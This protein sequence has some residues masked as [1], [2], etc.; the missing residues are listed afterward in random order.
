[1]LGFLLSFRTGQAYKRFWTGAC[2]AHETTNC[3]FMAASNLVAFVQCGSGDEK[4]KDVFR[5][6]IVRLM[7]MLNSMMLQELEGS[8]ITLF[9]QIPVMDADSLGKK[10]LRALVGE[11]NK[12]QLVLQWIKTLVIESVGNDVLSVP[13]PILTR[14]FQELD[15][16]MTKFHSAENISLVPFPFPYAATMEL[17]L[18]MHTL[19]TPLVMMNLL[20]ASSVLPSGF[21]ALISF[22]LW[23]IHL[24]AGELEDPFTAGANDLDLETLQI[25]LNEK[26]KTICCVNSHQVP[27]LTVDAE[28]ASH[29]LLAYTRAPPKRPHRR[30]VIQR[31]IDTSV[32][33]T[34]SFTSTDAVS[35]QRGVSRPPTFKGGASVPSE[36][37]LTTCSNERAVRFASEETEEHDCG[38]VRR[39][40]GRLRSLILTRISR[41][42]PTVESPSFS[43]TEVDSSDASATPEGHGEIAPWGLSADVTAAADATDANV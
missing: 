25:A 8:D 30:T 17:I 18:I 6:T 4:A 5:Q 12:T 3:V 36:D 11:E 23:S 29:R 33:T 24:V 40:K 14:V 16:S 15:M 13:P 2:A 9:S 27:R 38:E 32:K 26:L 19:C 21:V 1:V 39:P 43:E 7:S 35:P 22:F 20:P 28:V 34:K 10:E 42:L 31:A 41:S 37:D